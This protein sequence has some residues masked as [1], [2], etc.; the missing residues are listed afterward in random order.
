ML[1]KLKVC[2]L[3][4]LPVLIA[5]TLLLNSYHS[6]VGKVGDMIFVVQQSVFKLPPLSKED[7]QKQETLDSEIGINKLLIYFQRTR[8]I[9]TSPGTSNKQQV[10]EF[11]KQPDVEA[12]TPAV[13]Q[14][15]IKN[16]LHKIWLFNS[17]V[18][19][20]FT[21]LPFLLMAI[22]LAFSE[23][24]PL[25][26]QER[27]RVA[28]NDFFMK[29]MLGC[30][31]ATCWIYILN[32][33]G[34]GAGTMESYLDGVDLYRKE[35][36]PI[37]LQSLKIEPIVS[38]LL[39]WYLHALSYIFTKITRHDVASSLVFSH[40]FKKFLLVYGIA[41][42]LPPTNVIP[43]EKVSLVVFML[44][45]FPLIAFS[46]MKEQIGKFTNS[47]IKGGDL[48]I[49]PGISRYQILR[50]EEEGI[51]TMAELAA[52]DRQS[53]AATIPQMSRIVGYWIDIARLYV[54][55]G[56]EHY[57]VI[58]GRCVTASGF[59]KLSVEADFVAFIKEKKLGNCDEIVSG[60]KST[61][62]FYKS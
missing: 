24:L 57:I 48:S 8:Q 29:L 31:I 32:P 43:A 49:L 23:Q 9:L 22:K 33:Q 62:V 16:Q 56:H 27:S 44:G 11:N 6:R 26:Q 2:L 58:N 13:Q 51:D 1:N 50:L 54:I 39:G 53:I 37:Y 5:L 42:I 7:E 4:C 41:L 10:F 18:V 25:T 47:Q 15:R 19:F 60:I 52:A 45:F 40:L 20:S 14:A 34:R 30:I 36:L 17:T 61:F 3:Y 38:G 55:V 35:T 12:Q 46:F 21:L 59:I 28:A